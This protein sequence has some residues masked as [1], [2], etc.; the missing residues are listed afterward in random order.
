VVGA[1][2]RLADRKGALVQGAGAVEVAL[3]GQDVGEVAEAAGGVGVVGAKPRLADGQGALVQAAGG[4]EVAL[5]RRTLARLLRLWA[6]VG[7][8]APSRAS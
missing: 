8:S 1:Q 7:W 2:A 4:V 6:V 5:A 3:V